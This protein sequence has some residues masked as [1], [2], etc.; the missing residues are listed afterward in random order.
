MGTIANETIALAQYL[1]PGF[2]AAWIFYGLT[3][4]PKPDQFERVIQALIFT[5]ITQAIVFF[6]KFALLWIGQSWSIMPWNSDS[7]LVCA[8][9]TAVL[10]G[11]IFAYFANHDGFH[12]VA[13]R[14]GITR[15]TSFP[16]EWFGAFLKNVTYIVLHLKDDRRLYGWPIEWPSDPKRGQFILS[17]PSWLIQKD[18]KTVEE[19]ITGVESVLLSVEDV[20]WVEFLDKVWE[21]HNEPKSS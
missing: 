11:G 6:E 2:L 1:L 13:R 15:E 3:S 12:R 10:I 9:I 17:Q 7:E 18:G 21:N 4:H 16:S 20:K 8:T 19:P 5:L 14:A